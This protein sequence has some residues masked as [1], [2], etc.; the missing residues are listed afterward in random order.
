MSFQQWRKNITHVYSSNISVPRRK[1]SFPSL[2]FFDNFC[3]GR[4]LYYM[5]SPIC[6]CT[7]QEWMSSLTIDTQNCYNP[8]R[9]VQY[10]NQYVI[11][12]LSL[13]MIR[14]CSSGES[15]FLGLHSCI[16]PT[17]LECINPIVSALCFHATLASYSPKLL[18]C[19]MMI[20]GIM[21]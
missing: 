1:G 19:I 2:G 7:T 11:Y 14:E 16:I 21:H 10:F 20:K 3:Y 13:V 8:L 5:Y 15:T 12:M 6:I 9:A 4:K 17:L 18:P